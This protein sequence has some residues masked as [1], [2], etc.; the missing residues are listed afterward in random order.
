VSQ[1][2]VTTVPHHRFVRHPLGAPHLSPLR[3]H[4]VPGPLAA[5]RCLR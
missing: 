2:G 5:L 3:Q 1:R 4:R